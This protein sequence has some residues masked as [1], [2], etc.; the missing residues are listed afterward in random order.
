MSHASSPRGF[1][2]VPESRIQHA[3]ILFPEQ[4]AFDVVTSEAFG[5]EERYNVTAVGHWSRVS[6]RRLDVTFGSWHA[7][8]SFLGPDH[9]AVR[10]SKA[11]IIQVWLTSSFGQANA[12]SLRLESGFCF[13]ADGSDHKDIVTP[14]DR[15]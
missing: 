13:T 4:L 11:K 9:A 10:L 15:T 8:V 6:L 1:F 12:S 3:E 7:F 14:D 2:V 5:T